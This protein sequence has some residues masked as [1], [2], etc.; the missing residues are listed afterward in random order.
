MHPA[1]LVVET[2]IDEE[3][4]P[5][6]RAVGVEALVADHLQFRTEEKRGVRVD[7]K[8]GLAIERVRRRDRRTVRPARLVIVRQR[9]VDGLTGVLAKT[10]RLAVERLQL[11]DVHALD[12]AADAALRKRQRH[13]RDRN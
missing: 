8:Q 6:G 11:A 2:L 3:L 1:N 10:G 13:P 4:T 5:R 9:R 7:E 12:V